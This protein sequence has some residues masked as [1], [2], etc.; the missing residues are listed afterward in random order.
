MLK[1]KTKQLALHADV[2]QEDKQLRKEGVKVVPADQGLALA[3]IVIR[4]QLISSE[5]PRYFLKCFEF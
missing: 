1:I 2:G 3:E 5:L 4:C